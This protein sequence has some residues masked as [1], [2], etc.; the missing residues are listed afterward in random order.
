M[1]GKHPRKAPGSLQI[2]EGPLSANSK[3]SPA[4]YGEFDMSH[5]LFPAPI[6][7]LRE[8]RASA[9]GRIDDAAGNSGRRAGPYIELTLRYVIVRKLFRAMWSRMITTSLRS[10][11]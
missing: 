11:Y 7:K 5:P 1:P 9:P 4:S 3:I 2:S 10:S 8:I 6:G